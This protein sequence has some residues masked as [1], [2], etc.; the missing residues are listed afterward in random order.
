MER[1]L[2]TL[3]KWHN[4]YMNSVEIYH[5]LIFQFNISCLRCAGI[6]NLDLTNFWA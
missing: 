4:N 1:N 2:L 3:K 5:R 6:F